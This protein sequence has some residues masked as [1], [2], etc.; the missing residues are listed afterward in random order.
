M[1]SSKD[2]A[3]SSKEHWKASIDFQIL[4]KALLMF[5]CTLR[6]LEIELSMS[7]LI[8]L[9]TL[10][11]EVELFTGWVRRVREPGPTQP[12]LIEFSQWRPDPT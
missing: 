11:K 6:E 1:K 10:I 9:E 4:A 2:M 3:N 12:K 5:V 7:I 8:L